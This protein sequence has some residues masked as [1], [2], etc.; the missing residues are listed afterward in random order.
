MCASAES[1]GESTG[2]PVGSSVSSLVTDCAGTA[3]S[4]LHSCFIKNHD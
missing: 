3:G 1:T 4:E 2:E